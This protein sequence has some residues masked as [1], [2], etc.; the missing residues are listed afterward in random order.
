MPIHVEHCMLSQ[1]RM[2][3]TAVLVGLIASGWTGA[4]NSDSPPLWG[5]LTPGPYAVGFVSSWQLDYSRRYNTT[6]D[7]KKSYAT[8][9]APRPILINMWYP[10]SDA[11]PGK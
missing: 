6:F 3:G 4:A 10:A 8:G 11:A 1:I 9:K 7:D 5:K 2:L